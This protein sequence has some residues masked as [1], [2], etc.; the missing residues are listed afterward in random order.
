[1]T[2]HSHSGQNKSKEHRHPKPIAICNQSDRPLLSASISLSL[3]LS[4]HYVFVHSF[5][6]FWDSKFQTH[7]N[8]LCFILAVRSNQSDR[9]LCN[10][11]R[12]RKPYSFIFNTIMILCY[13]FLLLL[14]TLEFS[15]ETCYFATII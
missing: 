1:M 5:G 6:S 15:H 4:K 2:L 10:N 8:V 11:Y 14:F 13:V 3:F 7:Q 12:K 9:S